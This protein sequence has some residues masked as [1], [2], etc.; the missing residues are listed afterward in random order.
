M[1]SG[2]QYDARGP[3]TGATSV[4]S[5]P[6]VEAE[7]VAER[8]P[9]PN[10]QKHLLLFLATC[11]STFLGYFLIMRGSVQD[12]A[13]Y[14]ALVMLILTC[15]EL[16]HFFQAMRYRVPASLPYFI[17]FPVSPIGTMGAVIAMHSRIPNRKALFDIGI[18]G[19]LAGLV[20]AL[21]CC[22]V[23]LEQASIGKVG[24]GSQV[25]GDPL[26]LKYLTYLKFG[27]LQPGEDVY[28]NAVLFA[29]WVGLFITGLNLFPI[30][31]LDGGHVLYAI[32]EKRSH[33][34]ATTVLYAA[35]AAVMLTGNW[36]WSVMLLLLFF[37]GPKHPPTADDSVPL[38]LP[39]VVLGWI[40]LA[41][42]V[43]SFTPQPFKPPPK[44]FPPPRQISQP[45]GFIVERTA[46]SPAPLSTRLAL[47][48]RVVVD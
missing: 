8:P 3:V 33:L 29:G 35:I 27:P 34:V 21:I 39:R 14:A 42:L 7:V 17:P 10:Y 37:I 41:F 26:L 2:D 45:R 22:V 24:P 13:T 38:G 48:E 18:T 32:L 23:G 5:H 46:P 1:S 31:Q 4:Y 20:P 44:R 6:Y 36:A 11:A 16:G 12:S 40:T 15:H 19:P 30:G 47:D 9:A 25:F 43:I 28:F